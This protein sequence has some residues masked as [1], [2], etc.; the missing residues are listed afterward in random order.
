MTEHSRRALLLS[1]GLAAAAIGLSGCQNGGTG[2][3]TPAA[4][5]G[6]F[7]LKLSD[8]PVGSG[9]IASGAPY[10]ITQPTAGQVKAF[11]N[12][13]THQHCPVSRVE[14]AEIICDCHGSRFSITDGSVTKG[15]ATQALPAATAKV[16][17][18]SVVVN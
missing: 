15:P 7:T 17:G 5:T 14:K 9:V 2:T 6:K 10:V 1:T 13:C 4:P 12:V 16:E 3:P 11:S 18:D 8:V